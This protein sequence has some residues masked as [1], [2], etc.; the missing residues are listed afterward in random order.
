MIWFQTNLGYYKTKDRIEKSYKISG[1]FHSWYGRLTF[2]FKDFKDVTFQ[3]TTKGKL[4]IYYS[5][6][7]SYENFL[8]KIKPFLVKVDGTP[9]EIVHIIKESSELS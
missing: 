3:I 2:R 6:E 5:E 8:E 1:D 9:S 4:G 7:L